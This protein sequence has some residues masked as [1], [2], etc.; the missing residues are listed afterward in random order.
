M[1]LPASMLP[2]LAKTLGLTLEELL[3]QDVKP[4]SK[5]GPA[6][7]LDQQIEIIRKLPK[8]KQQTVM[9]MLDMVIASQS[10]H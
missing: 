7:R 1:R 6:S 2:A 5:R 8:T 9:E 3:G 10:G 4:K